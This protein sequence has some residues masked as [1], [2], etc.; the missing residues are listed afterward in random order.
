MLKSAGLFREN[1]RE[2]FLNKD[3]EL[4]MTLIR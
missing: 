1:P 2:Q 4:K 3:L